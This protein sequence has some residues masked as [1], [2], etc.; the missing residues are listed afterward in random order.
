MALPDTKERFGQSIQSL[1]P[2]ELHF[3]RSNGVIDETLDMLMDMLTG[4]EHRDIVREMLLVALKAGMESDSIADLKLMNTTLKEMRYTTKVF[5]PYRGT[6]KITVFGSARF[7]E[8]HEY[9]KMA[10]EVGRLAALAPHGRGNPAPRGVLRGL[11]GSER[12]RTF[13]RGGDHPEGPHRRR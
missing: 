1:I 9:Y 12:A 2:D 11:R 10:R 13:G 3:G 5:A 8:D 6:R 7:D 4:I